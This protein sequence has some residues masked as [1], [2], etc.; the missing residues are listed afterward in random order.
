MP[1]SGAEM[2]L[3]DQYKANYAGA[4]LFGQQLNRMGRTFTR[5]NLKGLYLGYS[6]IKPD[7]NS[8]YAKP[9]E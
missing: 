7:P 3:A 5:Q 2:V 1:V 6:G 9:E 4:D 8:V